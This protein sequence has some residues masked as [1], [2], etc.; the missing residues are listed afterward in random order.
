MVSVVNKQIKYNIKAKKR[1]KSDIKYFVIHYTANYSK[2]ATALMHYNYFNS[3]NKNASADV[4]V[5]ENSIYKINDWFNYYTWAV[6][7]GKSKYGITNQNS[8]NIEIC[9]NGN[10]EKAIQNTIDY[11]KYLKN[12]GYNINEKTLVRH[13]DASR[14]LCPKFFVDLHIKGYNKDYAD[15][16]NK[17]LKEGTSMAEKSFEEILKE[18]T[19]DGNEWIKFVDE[20]GKLAG[21]KSDLGFLEKAVYLPDLIRKV[22]YRKK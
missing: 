3:G 12:L 6:G 4:F 9:V 20:C 22:Y 7:D 1:T 17:V 8:V 19:L 16:R 21:Q 10:L 11:L 15:F 2:S 14:K 18:C 13:Y 5:D